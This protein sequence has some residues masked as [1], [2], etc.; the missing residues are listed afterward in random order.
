MYCLYLRTFENIYY[1]GLYIQ[2]ADTGGL[3]ISVKLYFTKRNMPMVICTLTGVDC[4]I[5]EIGRL[6]TDVTTVLYNICYGVVLNAVNI[7]I[8]KV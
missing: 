6:I 7:I 5:I 2:S 1:R 4:K 8:I 3:P